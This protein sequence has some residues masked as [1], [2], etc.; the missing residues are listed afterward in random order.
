MEKERRTDIHTPQRTQLTPPQH[1]RPTIRCTCGSPPVAQAAH[2]PLHTCFT[3]RHTHGSHPATHAAHTQQLTRRTPLRKR[4]LHPAEHAAHTPPRT[5]KREGGQQEWSEG[6]QSAMVGRRT[7]TRK[8]D[9]R[10]EGRGT[11]MW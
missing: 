3:S 11:V 8:V 2:T 1:T 5:A 10:E 9:R 4:G 7:R 6:G